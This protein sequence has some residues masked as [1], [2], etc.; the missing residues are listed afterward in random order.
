[1]GR[2]PSLPWFVEN[3]R[4]H[5]LAK[6]IGAEIVFGRRPTTHEVS[7]TSVIIVDVRAGDDVDGFLRPGANPNRQRGAD[8]RTHEHK[9]WRAAACEAIVIGV[10][11]KDGATRADHVERCDELV[12]DFIAA[13]EEVALEYQTRFEPSGGGA[14]KPETETEEGVEAGYSEHGARYR[15][16]FFLT[17]PIVD[18][19]GVAT[20]P[21]L[22]TIRTSLD[23][24]GTAG[25]VI[26][27]TG[28]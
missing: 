20:A 23:V 24:N 15:L 1:M 10:S 17:V 13:A 21:G 25:D 8:L 4:A 12:N 16:R 6:K 26:D 14:M 28:S 5:P 3:L 27:A 2:I 9:Y 22:G 11:T 7:S 18:R 19:K